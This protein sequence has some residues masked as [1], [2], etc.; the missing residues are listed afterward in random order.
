MS[1]DALLVD[2]HPLFRAGF[3][4]AWRRGVGRGRI[5]EAGS[6]AEARTRLRQLARLDAT[7]VDVGLPD[8]WGL[9]LV[10]ELV[11]RRCVTVVLTMFDKPA[12]A[13]AARH[14]GARGVFSKD[15]DPE[16]ILRGIDRLLLG[17][18]SSHF[19]DV[20]LPDLTQ[21]EL[22]V[23]GGIMDGLGNREIAE[24][25]GVGAETVKTHVSN[26]ID[27]LGATG[28]AGAARVARELGFDI[29]LPFLG[30]GKRNH[31]E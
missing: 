1:C 8:G 29:A 21:R 7:I 12:V 22:E 11:E 16:H 19:P 23:L 9:S 20:A 30:E 31:R 2:D 3:V 10:P 26:V 24:H 5:Y 15:M 28:R 14:L 6:L 13:V 18:G 27:R 17:Q 25:L 4:V